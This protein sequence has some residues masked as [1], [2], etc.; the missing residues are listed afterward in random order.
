M[1]FK[2]FGFINNEIIQ[3][4][5]IL[6]YG[7]NSSLIHEIKNIIIS[8]LKEGASFTIKKYQEEYLLQN[9]DIFNQI[10]NSNNLF[11]DEEI[12]LISKTT[13]KILEIFNEEIATNNNKKIIFLSE[14]LTKKSKFRAIGESSKHFACIACYQDNTEQLQSLLLQ[15]LK[16]IKISVSR[17][18]INSIFEMNSLNRQDINDAI[19]KAILIKN[20]SNIDENKLKELFH[21]STDNNN[22]EI[23]NDCLLGNKKNISIALNNIYAQGINFNEILSALKYKINKLLEIA[24]SNNDNK[25]INQ[26]VE[27]FRPAIFWKE[28][29]IVKDQLNRWSKK[30]LE[31]LLDKIF[32][33]EIQCKKNYD[34][35]TVILQNFV[36]N[37][38]TKTAL[39]KIHT[40]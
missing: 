17:Q 9:E 5:F 34:V 7:E 36:I 4:P 25:N 13:D 29:N 1:I 23:V 11:G 37:I 20:S 14:T 28:K 21:S 24:E 18:F 3:K 19:D 15:K 2:S 27:S 35:S 39:E 32:D 12:Y 10:I 40:Q 33:I 30:E 16:N 8:K 22:F 26:L 31:I 38:S 6:L